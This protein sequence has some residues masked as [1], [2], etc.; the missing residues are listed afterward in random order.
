M[1]TVRMIEGNGGAGGSPPS[2]PARLSDSPDQAR[3]ESF[4][5]GLGLNTDQLVD[6]KVGSPPLL[7]LMLLVK[8]KE[9][10]IAVSAVNGRFDHVSCLQA[11]ILRRTINLVNNA[12]MF[13]AVANDTTLSH[14]PATNFKLRFDERY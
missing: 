7:W 5:Q 13:L 9:F 6:G 11:Q 10:H 14:F 12:G 8:R 2:Q 4:Q 3:L 1:V